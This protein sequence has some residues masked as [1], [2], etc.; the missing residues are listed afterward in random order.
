MEIALTP[1]LSP[2][3]KAG[4]YGLTLLLIVALAVLHLALG[5]PLT[6]AAQWQLL[7][8][9]LAGLNDYQTFYA[10]WPRLL[11]A[12]LVGL[13]LGVSGSLIQQLTQNRLMSPMTLGAASGAWLALVCC[14]IWLPGLAAAHG[15]WAALSGALSAAALVLCIA[16][17]RGL[18]GLPL[19][20]AGMTIN[21][22]LGA[23][24]AAL[25][26]LH[27]QY[28]RELFMWG[29]GDLAQ[30]DWHMV[31][32]LLPQLWPLLPLI[33]FA[34]RPLT[35]LRIGSQGAEG[36]GMALVPVLLLLLVALW[37]SAVAVTAVGLIGFICLLTPNFAR[38]LGARTAADELLY[39]GV[40]GAALLLATDLLAVLAGQGGAGAV[41]TGVAAALLGAPG[42]LIFSLRQGNR[43]AAL[44]RPEPTAAG[45]ARAPHRLLRR[46]PLLVL[47][48]ALAS[49]CWLPGA[50][51]WQLA[52]P[53]ALIWSMR[54]PRTLVALAA[55]TGLAL[56]GVIL[57]RL[58]RNPLASPDILGLSAGATL[59]LVLTA[60]LLHQPLQQNGAVAAAGSVV[61]LLLLLWLGRRHRYAPASMALV[62]ISLAALLEAVLQFALTR[63]SADTFTILGWLAGS[64]YHVS[65]SQALWL[66]AEV[67]V[68]AALT[69]AGQRSLT[70]LGIGDAVAA[71]RGLSLGAAR[72]GWLSLA[73]LLTACVTS[74][75]GPISFLGLLAPHI[76]RLSGARRL[77]AQ[78]GLAALFGAALLLLADWLGR[79]LIYPAQLPVGI[80]ASVVCGLYLLGGLVL[81]RPRRRAS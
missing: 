23:I 45:A 69:F 81:L 39:S 59:A 36:R 47:A 19:V 38:S 30:N 54:W 53:D 24:T 71:G 5:S 80:V 26:L 48:F 60:L 65:G 62:G 7:G 29:A 21:L 20:L 46:L 55:G 22:L 37:L 34:P 35:L 73:A 78:L 4:R 67:A 28:V 42:L 51:G 72:L 57:Q 75:V 68:L 58:L 11:M 6:L 9:P 31:R 76:A 33:L 13:A 12:L 2:A 49:L 8:T 3:G 27:D 63:G 17:P 18:N 15:Q 32:W 1:A 40:L 77:P 64:T 14:T 56:A 44:A 41:P 16:G 70:L 25:I 52:W 74:L 79:V 43:G 61:V 10:S 50:D 66:A